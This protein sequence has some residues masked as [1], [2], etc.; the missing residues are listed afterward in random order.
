[1]QSCKAGLRSCSAL[2]SFGTRHALRQDR[3]MP[4]TVGMGSA[5]E[6]F[7][8]VFVDFQIIGNALAVRTITKN[9]SVRWMGE[10]K[11]FHKVLLG[12][13]P[14]SIGQAEWPARTPR[15]RLK[16][17]LSLLEPLRTPSPSCTA[18]FG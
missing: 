17:K 13:E 18:K 3:G 15:F 11:I 16:Q 5:G 9:Q 12:S 7:A 2:V 1:M 8:S 6:V 4:F 14:V 10:A